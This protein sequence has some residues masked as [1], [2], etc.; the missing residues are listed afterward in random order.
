[1]SGLNKASG[2]RKN[3][4][5]GRNKAFCEAYRRENRR[6]KNKALRLKKHIVRQ[7]NDTVGAAA[8]ERYREFIR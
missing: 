7:P 8:F 6:E 5:W 2:G 4:K 1:M 3:R